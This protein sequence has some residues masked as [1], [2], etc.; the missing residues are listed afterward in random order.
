MNGSGSA[1]GIPLPNHQCPLCGGPN[2]C[3]PAACGRFD[4]TCWCTDLPIPP[5]T[6]ARVP[7]SQ[8]GL[9]CLC[10]ACA[11]AATAAGRA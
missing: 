5:A 4:V 9:A 1:P 10:A 2:G 3:A 6:L 8:R 7:E 11:G